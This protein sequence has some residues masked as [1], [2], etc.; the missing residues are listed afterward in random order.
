MDFARRQILGAAAALPL[1]GCAKTIAFPSG[2]TAAQDRLTTALDRPDDLLAAL[3]GKHVAILTH[4]AG[5]DRTGRRSIDVLAGLPG[6]KLTA[7]WSPEHGLAG[8]AAAGDHIGDGRDAVTGLPVHSLYGARKAPTRTMLEAV[9]AVFVDL[10]D[11]GT[12]PYTYA[13]TMFEVLKAA[14]ATA[15]PIFVNDRPNP[16][17]GVVME[18]PM[19]D[20]ALSSFVG[21]WPIPLRHGL[22]LGELARMMNGEKMGGSAPIGA[23]LTI[24]PMQGWRRDMGAQAFGAGGLPFVPPS[25]NLRTMDAALAYAGTVLF[26]GTT[27][28]EG[29]GT[30]AP[31]LTL[32]APFLAADRLQQEIGANPIAGAIL[33]YDTLVPLAA[34]YKGERCGAIH[35]RVTNPARYRPVEAALHLIAALLRLYPDKM[36][37]LGGK[38]PFFDRLSGNAQLRE[39]L[40][41]G[42]GID[43]IIGGWQEPLSA[44]AVRRKP[45]LLY[46]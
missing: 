40:K 25:P 18:G 19:L 37:F 1:A 30:D 27:V 3:G 20:P 43:A 36:C 35:I 22:T 33:H 11:V 39:S 38:P 14:S 45:W 8:V 29:R 6:I 7:I 9:D 13:S 2:H 5:I 15:T 12:R 44:F 17:G 26:E 46:A 4:A 23:A 41:K 34:R 32:C 10:Q 21:V 31:F 24:L 28:S 42:V 16:L